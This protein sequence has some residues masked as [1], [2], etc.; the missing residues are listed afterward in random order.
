MTKETLLNIKGTSYLVCGLIITI[1]AA[2]TLL[3]IRRKKSLRLLRTMT[4]FII[5]IGMTNIIWG[6]VIVFIYYEFK[7][8]HSYVQAS[9]DAVGSILSNFAEF[10]IVWLVSF[11][12]WE[13]V[14]Q[15]TFYLN[16]DEFK[17]QNSFNSL[18]ARH[19]TYA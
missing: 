1:A 3:A 14:L 12:F 16:S 4:I 7:D 11:K 10:G 15:L 5:I 9:L 6:S 18:K 2:Q 17:T 8:M 13:T 19:E